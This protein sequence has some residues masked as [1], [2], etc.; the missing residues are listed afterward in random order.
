[1][2]LSS[3]IA[4]ASGACL[5]AASWHHFHLMQLP[6]CNLMSLACPQILCHLPA[7]PQAESAAAT[8]AQYSVLLINSHDDS[9]PW[10]H[11]TCD[12]ALLA[13]PPA[14][15]E[16][17]RAA[18]EARVAALQ[19]LDMAPRVSL[20]A[21]AAAAVT[22][23]AR[24]AA[25]GS[26]GGAAASAEAA[27]GGWAVDA[28]AVL[29]GVPKYE[30]LVHARKPGSD[31][32]SSAGQQE[33]S[34]Q[35]Q[36]LLLA[37]CGWD[38]STLPQRSSNS[39]KAILHRSA[40]PLAHL[41][42][43]PPA[44]AGAAGS[45]NGADRISSSDAMLWCNECGATAGLWTF[46]CVGPLYLKALQL[47]AARA[48]ALEATS[49]TSLALPAASR[50]EASPGVPGAG[51]FGTPGSANGHEHAEGG[52]VQSLFQ[53]IAGG[54]LVAAPRLPKRRFGSESGDAVF[55]LGAFEVEAKR[56]RSD[57]SFGGSEFGV[58]RAGSEARSDMVSPSASP[59][60][61]T[62]AGTAGDTGAAH[63]GSNGTAGGGA[64][65][66]GSTGT[67][68]VERR[69]ST[70]SLPPLL[71]PSLLS[72]RPIAAAQADRPLLDPIEQHRPWCPWVHAHTEFASSRTAATQGAAGAGAAGAGAAGTAA[73]AGGVAG[74]ASIMAVADA[75]PT[76]GWLHCL[77][78]LAA[79]GHSMAGAGQLG[80]EA[81]VPAIEDAAGVEGVSGSMQDYSAKVRSALGAMWGGE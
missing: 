7:V 58:S 27:G 21:V 46:N 52:A 13:Y 68:Q 40:S 39:S 4:D 72:P 65:A 3:H 42:Q 62:T 53:T 28:L 43:P 33:L 19:R 35:Q 11:R 81:G 75:E 57:G 9:C 70:P 2:S 16:R 67:A 54:D 26:A 29:L 14:P 49:L 79:Q 32:W 71:P 12:Q 37:L 59:A 30:L 47:N 23:A 61:V 20:A 22:S 45:S 48:K 73:A 80:P 66:S 77:R 55:G 64:G 34:E 78:A 6:S 69:A 44:A 60:P 5:Y 41:V 31:N 10:K 51:V 63:A 50:R 17:L 24:M 56:R 76:C 38:I 25:R 18:F 15:E 74:T 36:L 1:M 8:I